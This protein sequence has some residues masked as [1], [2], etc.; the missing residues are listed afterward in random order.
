MNNNGGVRLCE[1]GLLCH[2][3]IVKNPLIELLNDGKPSG[4]QS[5]NARQSAHIVRVFVNALEGVVEFP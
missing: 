1:Q 3:S 4:S 5:C 2:A